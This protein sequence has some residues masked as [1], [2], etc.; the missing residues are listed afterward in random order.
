MFDTNKITVI[1]NKDG[2]V[3]L[4]MELEGEEEEVVAV[5]AMSFDSFGMLGLSMGLSPEGEEIAQN[6]LV[7]QPDQ[8]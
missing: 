5:L 3:T 2:S 6:M 1:D 4:T 8:F 7:I